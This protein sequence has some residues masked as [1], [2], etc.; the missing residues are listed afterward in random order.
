MEYEGFF[1]HGINTG[2]DG[3]TERATIAGQSHP[4]LVVVRPLSLPSVIVVLSARLTVDCALP[5]PDANGW[6]GVWAV[7]RTQRA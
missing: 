2:R 1:L 6:I 4:V 3:P 7:E 5:A